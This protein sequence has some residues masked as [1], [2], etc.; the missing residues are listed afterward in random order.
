MIVTRTRIVIVRH[1]TERASPFNTGILANRELPNSVLIDYGEVGQPL[2]LPPLDDTWLLFPEGT[3]AY[4]APEH[5]PKQLLVID[6][7]WPEAQ[8]MRR[9]FALPVLCLPTD[10]PL[11]TIEA[12][13][14]AI[15][16]LDDGW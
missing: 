6:A 11:K 3:P 1:Y 14:R 9:R 13:A 12:I 4:M 10:R 7:T 5:P 15:R 16:L 8:L 2:K